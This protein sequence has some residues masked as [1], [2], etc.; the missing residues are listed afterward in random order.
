MARNMSRV[1]AYEGPFYVY[2]P[3]EDKATKLTLENFPAD[4][5]RVWHGIGYFRERN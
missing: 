5:D 2:E 3:A 4:A 1:G